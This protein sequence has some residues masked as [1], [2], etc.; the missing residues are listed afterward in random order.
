MQIITCPVCGSEMKHTEENGTELIKGS[1]SSYSPQSSKNL[2]MNIIYLLVGALLALGGV[3]L[4]GCD[5][6]ATDANYETDSGTDELTDYEN[7]GTGDAADDTAQRAT[8]PAD[9]GTG[10]AVP[11]DTGTGDAVP[12][13]TGTGDAV[14][15]DTEIL[16]A[17]PDNC[18][19]LESFLETCNPR[20]LTP[21]KE[22]CTGGM[23]GYTF[24]V[25]ECAQKPLD[26]CQIDN[27]PFEC[28]YNRCEHY[29]LCMQLCPR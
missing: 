11:D 23:T 13:D 16:D 9:T 15:D 19:A 4:P 21:F 17:T 3:A 8:N 12:D 10:D 1:R 22:S 29:T 18:S 5:D 24:C 27:V 20:A 25:F 28:T 7:T 2:L 14:P 6:S 26:E